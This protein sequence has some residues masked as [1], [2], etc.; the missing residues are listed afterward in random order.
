MT[1]DQRI[2]KTT[3]YHPID[4]PGLVRIVKPAVAW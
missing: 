1:P 2:N 3:L 4:L